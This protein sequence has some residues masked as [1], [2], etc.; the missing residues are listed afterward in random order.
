MADEDL[1]GDIACAEG[2]HAIVRET[3]GKNNEEDE[4]YGQIVGH[5]EGIVERSKLRWRI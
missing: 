1:R 4:K 3:E 2:I 5:W